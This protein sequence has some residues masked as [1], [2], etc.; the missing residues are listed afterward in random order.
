MEYTKNVIYIDSVEELKFVT[1]Y[2]EIENKIKRE[3]VYI[4]TFRS[5]D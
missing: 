4:R 2:E 1:K 3:L 5:L